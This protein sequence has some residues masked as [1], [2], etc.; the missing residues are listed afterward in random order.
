V[1]EK[2]KGL[3][4]FRDFFSTLNFEGIDGKRSGLDSDPKEEGSPP[5]SLALIS[6][7][8]IA[9]LHPP[10]PPHD[11]GQA[12]NM[13]KKLRLKGTPDQEEAIH[14]F[15]QCPDKCFKEIYPIAEAFLKIKNLLQGE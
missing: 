11:C 3:E 15:V 10:S 12:A 9:F 1:D 14:F 6:D 7:E 4:V 2:Y 5:S 8:V 13:L